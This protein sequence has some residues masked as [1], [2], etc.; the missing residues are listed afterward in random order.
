MSRLPQRDGL[1]GGNVFA[2][3]VAKGTETPQL[4]APESVTDLQL[5]EPPPLPRRHQKAPAVG[6]DRIQRRDQAPELR[7]VCVALACRSRDAFKDACS[8]ENPDEAEASFASAK[9]LIED[10]WE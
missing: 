5:Y 4:P 9:S 10:L 8:S 1:T 6:D 2:P 7:D 3:S